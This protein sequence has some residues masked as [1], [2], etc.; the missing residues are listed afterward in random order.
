[1]CC[2]ADRK[3]EEMPILSVFYGIIVR[4]YFEPLG[5]HNL[6]HI[7]V[8]ASGEE[9]T[10]ALDGT[11]LAGSIPANKLRILLAWMEIHKEDL[12]TNWKMLSNNEPHVKIDPLK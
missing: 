1:M 11:I 2:H 8:E 3:G 10:I 6:P 12:E 4:M 9:I 7:H 5:K